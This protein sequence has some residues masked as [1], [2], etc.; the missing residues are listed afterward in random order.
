MTPMIDIVFLLIIF[1]M[2]VSQLNQNMMPM[3]QLPISE[4]GNNSSNSAALVLDLD[5]SGR[6]KF[7]SAVVEQTELKGFLQLQKDRFQNDHGLPKVKVR[8][9]A[10]CETQHVNYVFDQMSELGF[11]FV[12]IAVNK[13]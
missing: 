2:T 12:S 5:A 6:L 8:C 7:G 1:F 4:I 3:V 9:D 13:P 10:Q 11:Q